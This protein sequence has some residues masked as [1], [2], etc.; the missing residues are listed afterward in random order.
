MTVKVK[1]LTPW[2]GDLPPWYGDFRRVISLNKLVEHELIHLV[3]DCQD[4]VGKG[5]DQYL[6]GGG[7]GV[8]SRLVSVKTGLPC[9]KNTPRACCDLR[10]LFG[11][12]FE[13]R[14]TGYEWFGWCDL[15][16]LTG[17]LDEL[18]VPRLD[19]LDL[20]TVSDEQPFGSL[21]LVRNDSRL[22]KAVLNDPDYR[23][24]LRNSDYGNYDEVGFIRGTP[25]LDYLVRQGGFRCLFDGR[26]WDEGRL[27]N[28]DGSDAQEWPTRVPEMRGN[29]LFELPDGRE[30]VCYHFGSKVWPLQPDGRPIRHAC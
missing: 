10:P 1:L 25:S 20:Y 7:C 26:S 13:D 16:I 12:L 24:L 27:V 3:W 8:L 21:T 28:V 6:I 17:N 15:D 22:T 4:W 19:N 9:A 18:V 14:L 5:M 23:E 29:R 11:L 2:F 30:I